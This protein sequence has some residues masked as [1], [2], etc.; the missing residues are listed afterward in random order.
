[1]NCIELSLDTENIIIN[2]IILKMREHLLEVEQKLTD[3]TIGF[4]DKQI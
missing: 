1:L 4:I 3:I 2:K